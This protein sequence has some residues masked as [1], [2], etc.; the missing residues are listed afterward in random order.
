MISG[1]EI[2]QRSH[3]RGAEDGAFSLAGV[4]DRVDVVEVDQP[5]GDEEQDAGHGRRRQVGGERGD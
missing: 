3:Q 5:P 1:L 2:E 4:P